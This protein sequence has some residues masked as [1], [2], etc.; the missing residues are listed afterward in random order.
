MIGHRRK[1]I[2][3]YGLCIG[4][5][6]FLFCFEHSYIISSNSSMYNLLSN[7]EW[8]IYFV[9]VGLIIIER[10]YSKKQ[11]MIIALGGVLLC[12]V[13]I[14]SG[15]AAPLKMLIVI[16]ASRKRRFDDI[17]SIIFYSYVSAILLTIV[18]YLLG[19]SDSGVQRRG[20]SALGFISAN[21]IGGYILVC[22]LI[23]MY[24]K[25]NRK[26]TWMITVTLALLVYFI[27][28]NRSVVFLILITP[29]CLRYF[30]YLVQ[31][32]K[33]N[34]WWKKIVIWLPV[35]CIFSC[36]ITAE[37]YPANALIQKLDM[38]FNQRIYLNYR[39]ITLYGVKV[40]GQHVLWGTG[41]TFYNSV[42]R[43][44]SDYNTVDNS[45]VCLLIQMGAITTAAYVLL[46]ARVAKKMFKEKNAEMLCFIVILALYGMTESSIIDV[47]INVPLISLMACTLPSSI[48]SKR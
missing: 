47:F 11:L 7:S 45:Y 29:L 15:Y 19:I 21:V 34:K 44:Y 38:I 3:L 24:K 16:M 31:S 41:Q 8:I 32:N 43:T 40:F 22:Y 10:K 27:I 13:Y 6:V 46:Y 18:L 28:N 14:Q 25:K 4:I 17:A 2:S 30:K 36:I 42:T 9:L 5:L 33:D 39:N 1:A 48:E 26:K 23:W 20:Y 35:I 37:M 12:I